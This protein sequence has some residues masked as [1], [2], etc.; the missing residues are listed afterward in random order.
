MIKIIKK[1]VGFTLIEMI[2]SLAVFS[3]VVTTAVGALLVVISTNQQLQEE[4][5][6][7]TNLAF[8]LD[9]MTRELRTGFSYVCGH[10]NHL[11][12]KIDAPGGYHQRMFKSS[13]SGPGLTD[14]DAM[15][16]SIVR[17]CPSGTGGFA[18][19]DNY[20]GVSFIE[21]GN[22]ITAGDNRILYYMDKNIA[23]DIKIMRR[24]GNNIPQSILSSGI[25]IVDAEFFVS[26][27]ENLFFADIDTE[28]PT[29]TI[30]IEAKAKDGDPTS[31]SYALQTTI[32]QRTFD[33]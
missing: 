6:I 31:N 28:Q 4:Q 30:Y 22:S 19:S 12:D 32:T 25:E 2:V 13:G 29:V 17:D 14:H 18:S 15:D 21:G 16:K 11:N 23:N 5:N 8:A 20:Q 9:S 24:V 10:T 3:I 26:G 1:Q 27:S 33:L 7:M